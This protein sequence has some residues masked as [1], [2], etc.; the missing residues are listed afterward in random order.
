MDF[1]YTKVCGWNRRKAI[2]IQRGNRLGLVKVLEFKIIKIAHLQQR[3][4]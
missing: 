4:F 2:W 3:D 1:D